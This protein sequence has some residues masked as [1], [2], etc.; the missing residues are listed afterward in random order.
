MSW[1]LS[2][3]GPRPR[4][5]HL[6]G[7]P[8]MGPVYLS[9]L[10]FGRRR[11]PMLKFCRNCE[12]ANREYVGRTVYVPKGRPSLAPPELLTRLKSKGLSCA[13]IASKV[14][15]TP[16]RVSQVLRA[17]KVLRSR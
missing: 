15:V 10:F 2:S 7:V 8:A 13:E 3:F 17:T 6:I 4:F 14:G 1:Q 11:S 5:G 16:R 12:E 9:G